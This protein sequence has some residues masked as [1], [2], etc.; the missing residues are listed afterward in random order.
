MKI[1]FRCHS[2]DSTK[3]VQD[4]DVADVEFGKVPVM[5]FWPFSHFRMSVEECCLGKICFRA[6][7]NLANR[8]QTV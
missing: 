1:V 3:V 7:W 5:V 2:F 6:I 4:P 8:L